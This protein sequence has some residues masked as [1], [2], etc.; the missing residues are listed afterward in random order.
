M[1]AWTGAVTGSVAV[2][3]ASEA[4]RAVDAAAAALRAPLGAQ[5]RADVLNAAAR[6]VEDRAEVFAQTI[7]AE[8]SK[9]ISAARVEV[10]R[11]IGTLRLSAVEAQRLPGETVPLDAVVAGEGTYAFTRPEPRGVVAAISP[12]N[13]PLNL[14]VHKVGPALAAG[15]P[16]VLKP[17]DRAPHTAGLL[18]QALHDAGLPAG[19]INLVTGPAALIVDAWQVD[20]RVEVI[21]FTGSSRIGW[22]LKSA[23]PR[24]LHILELGS[25]AAMYVD[26][27][28][29]IPRTVSDAVVAGFS[30]SGQACV[31]LQRVYVHSSIAEEFV[32]ALG[33][34]ASGIAYGDPREEGTVVGPLISSADTDRIVGWIAAAEAKGARIVTGGRV[35]AGVLV[36]TVLHGA[37]SDAAVVCEEI[38]G[39]VITVATVSSLAEGIAAVNDSH[40]GLNTSIYTADLASAMLFTREVESG[41]V[42]V[43]MPPSF[44]ADHMPYGGVKDSGQGREGVRFA[45]EEMV[46]QKLVILKP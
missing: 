5:R 40:Y 19:W 31:S 15:C 21:T 46:R 30:N 12:F 34:A 8:T 18:V 9:P 1:D 32:S 37:P 14:V 28:A 17:S 7:R 42:L 13:F 38:F 44:R 26:A 29:D 22:G 3:G 10:A 25:N 4:A 33:E 24:K 35:D 20:P 41:T 27:G 43:N 11:A 36:P 16:V 6:L 2:A 23:S 45:V 39:P